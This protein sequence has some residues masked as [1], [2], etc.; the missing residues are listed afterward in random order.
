MRRI[1]RSAICFLV[2][3]CMVCIAPT[4][5]AQASDEEGKASVSISDSA[6]SDALEGLRITSGPYLQA[7]SETGVTI[8]WT[9]N[10]KCFSKVEFGTSPTDELTAFNSQHGLIGANATLHTVRISGLKPGAEYYYRAV[11]TEITDFQPYRVTYG[12]TVRSEW[13]SLST[14]NRKKDGFSFVVLNDRHEKVKPLRTALNSIRWDFVDLVFLNGDMLGQVQKEQQIFHGLVNP[15]TEF[16]A[17]R[18]PFIFVRGNH[19]AR[20]SLARTLMSYFPSESERYY[21]SF[22]Q[23]PVHFL[24]LDSGEDKEDSHKEYS[25][26]VDFDRYRDQ[27]TEWLKKEVRTAGFRKAKFRVAFVHMPLCGGG[28]NHGMQD[29]REKWGPLLDKHGIDLMIS[30]HTHRYARIMPE[31]GKH[32]YPILIGGTNTVIRAN[33]TK[34][35]MEMIVSADDETVKDSFILS[36]KSRLWDRLVGVFR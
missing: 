8:V 24:V 30:A 10:K 25:G 17:G 14:L 11:S 6:T 5:P 12:Q 27:E 19:E 29:I 26:L 32:A 4:L 2:V 20:G 33:V 22:G 15:C 9:T 13:S 31:K 3:Y 34:A 28:D 1:A 7:P 21:Y 35:Q 16:F 18:I 36:R 23:G